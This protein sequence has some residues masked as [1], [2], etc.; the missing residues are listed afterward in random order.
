MTLKY[1]RTHFCADTSLQINFCQSMR[2]HLKAKGQFV[3]MIFLILC[4]SSRLPGYLKLKNN[5]L[6]NIA[7]DINHLIDINKTKNST[8]SFIIFLVCTFVETMSKMLYILKTSL[9]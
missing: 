6:S 1:Q 7:L 9:K 4:N 2:L 8:I 5:W 3:K